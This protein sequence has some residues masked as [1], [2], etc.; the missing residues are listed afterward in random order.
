MYLN[1]LRITPAGYHNSETCKASTSSRHFG[2]I[3]MPMK[4]KCFNLQWNVIESPILYFMLR[5]NIAFIV[6]M[7][8]IGNKNGTSSWKLKIPIKSIKQLINNNK[9]PGSHATVTTPLS[10]DSKSRCSSNRFMFMF[11]T[12]CHFATQLQIDF[13]HYCLVLGSLK[14]VNHITSHHRNISRRRNYMRF[15]LVYDGFLLF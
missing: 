1:F 12:N 4:L 13:D 9:T 10:Q 3:I 2:T 6:S 5:T 14:L 15:N 8:S 7:S 11:M